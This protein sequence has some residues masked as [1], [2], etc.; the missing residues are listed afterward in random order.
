MKGGKSS[1]VDNIPTELLKYGG[2]N[3]VNI[4]TKICQNIWSTKQWPA[5]W[6]QSLII[7]IP[8]K[9]NLKVCTNYRTISLITH[10]S[11]VMLK[12]LLNRI[13][14]KSE[15][16][17]AEEQAG[18]RANRSTVEQIFNIRTL[19]EKHIQHQRDLYHNFIDFTKAFDR[20]WHDGLWHTLR[21]FNFD[22][23]IIDIV[24]SLYKNANS[25]VLSNNTIGEFFKTN[26][27]VR[28]GCIMSPVLFNI[29]LEH[30]IQETLHDYNTSNRRSLY[31]QLAFR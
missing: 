21:Q 2:I 26:V 24:E 29:Y 5:D 25:A 7:P 22:T 1:G 8:K 20:V 16:I 4:M 31:L 30:I 10:P 23:T 3:V 28:Q 19:I 11:K 9:G 17:I 14:H 12:I 27:G 18:F 15:E 6:T 13:K